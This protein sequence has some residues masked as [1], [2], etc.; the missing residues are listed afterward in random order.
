M[1][2]KLNFNKTRGGNISV[3]FVSVFIASEEFIYVKEAI[4]IALS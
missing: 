4:N 3:Y 1:H 2:L